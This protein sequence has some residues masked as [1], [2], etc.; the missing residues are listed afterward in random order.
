MKNK[1][2]LLICGAA[3]LVLV[4]VYYVAAFTAGVAMPGVCFLVV[5][6]GAVVFPIIP[7]RSA[8]AKGATIAS[9][10]CLAAML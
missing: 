1:K 6:N 3:L 10:L 7:M 4:Q 2:M 8:A 5:F 9:V